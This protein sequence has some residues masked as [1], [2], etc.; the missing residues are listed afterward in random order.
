MSGPTRPVRAGLLPT[1]LSANV[2]G[3]RGSAPPSI[4]AVEGDDVDSAIRPPG[5]GRHRAEVGR[6]PTDQQLR[7]QRVLIVRRR[8][9]ITDATRDWRRQAVEQK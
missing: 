5:R 1:P 9:H 2:I 6:D 8:A 7:G 4:G 3:A